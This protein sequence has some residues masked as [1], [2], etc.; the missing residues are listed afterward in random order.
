MF[1]LVGPI[2]AQLTTVGVAARTEARVVVAEAP[3]NPTVTASRSYGAHYEAGVYPTIGATLTEK[4]LQLRAAYSPAFTVT[5][6]E[7]SSRELLVLHMITAGGSY[8]WRRTSLTIGNT[9]SFGEQNFR[10]LA[11]SSTPGASPTPPAGSATPPTTG[12]GSAGTGA[13]ATGG[14]TVPGAPTT[15]GVG[16]PANAIPPVN[17]SLRFLNYSANLGVGHNLSQS[18]TLGASAGYGYAGPRDAEWHVIYP[19]V[20]GPSLAFTARDQLSFADAINAGLSLQYAFSS[21]GSRTW[22]SNGTAG[23]THRFN[24]QTSSS[25]SGGAGI[26]RNSLP[27]GTI[28][29][30]IYPTFSAGLVHEKRLKPGFLTLGVS[31]TAAPALDFNSLVID[32][33]LS[34]AASAAYTRDSFFANA[35][36]GTAYS[37]SDQTRGSFSGFGGGAGLGYRFSTYVAVDGG[38]RVAYQAYQGATSLPF[39]YAGYVGVSVGFS[40]QL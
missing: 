1:S 7:S 38:V 27:N 13:P 33:R 4:R 16:G 32:P 22:N 40:D 8:G 37:I 24:T 36:I 26:A 2:L 21:S 29:Y 39:T 14:S 34:F 6:L 9:V 10:V 19:T 28:S 23:W 5:P 18:I 11:T 25:L 30:T 31:T 3:A 15:P 35:S 12:S 17:R 20:Q